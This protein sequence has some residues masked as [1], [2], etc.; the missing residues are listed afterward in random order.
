MVLLP[1]PPPDPFAYAT[2]FIDP[3]PCNN[4][5]LK[6]MLRYA[7]QTSNP[8]PPFPIFSSAYPCSSSSVDGIG[9]GGGT[10]YPLYTF[11]RSCPPFSSSTTWSEYVSALNPVDNCVQVYSSTTSPIELTTPLAF[12]Q[13]NYLP[14]YINHT[15][16][17]FIYW[18]IFLE[19]TSL[20]QMCYVPPN[21]EVYFFRENPSYGDANPSTIEYWKLEPGQLQVDFYRFYSNKGNSFLTYVLEDITKLQKRWFNLGPYVVIRQLYS[22]SEL[23]L[24]MCIERIP[25][26]FGIPT[27]LL[28]NVW[29]P[30]TAA[31]DSLV[32][33]V[34]SNGDASLVVTGSQVT[35]TDACACFSQQRELNGL[36]G[37]NLNVPVCCF[38][39][40][41]SNG[42]ITDKS[43]S[44]N[45]AAYKTEGMLKG[46]CQLAECQTLAEKMPD[47]GST[48]QIQCNGNFVV[49]PTPTPTTTPTATPSGSNRFMN[50]TTTTT[51]TPTTTPTTETVTSYVIPLWVWGILGAAGLLVLILLILLVF[52]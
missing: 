27:N 34:C 46:C 36:F 32:S 13:I 42:K 29:E 23:L 8:V 17:Y 10:Q 22:F 47:P 12:N 37:P 49:F 50:A 16:G 28:N 7:S 3:T 31:C 38:G 21:Y 30:Q 24:K 35:M 43:C 11:Y 52:M 33:N 41:T 14:V 44:L 9:T 18:N 39:T 15:E 51:T 2:S 19:V 5:I 45:E 6:D 25:V 26:Y 48:N 40:R 1:L 20:L 4:G